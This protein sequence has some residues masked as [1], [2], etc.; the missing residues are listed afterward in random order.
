MRAGS[1]GGVKPALVF[2]L[3][4]DLASSS[5]VDK[6]SGAGLQVRT[7]PEEFG[8]GCKDSDWLPRAGERGY[9]VL[10]RDQAI[11]RTPMEAAIVR[12]AR[13]LYFA[14]TSGNLTA[15]QMAAAILTAVPQIEGLVRSRRGRRAVMARITAGGKVNV[16]GTWP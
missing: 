7:V 11:R 4:E 15:T 14:L 2:L 16:S 12:E 13:V 10:T 3:D 5:I 9:V 1:R 6:L 8:R